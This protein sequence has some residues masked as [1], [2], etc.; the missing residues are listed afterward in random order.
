VSFN[1]FAAYYELTRSKNVLTFS[2]RALRTGKIIKIVIIFKKEHKIS[3]KMVCN[4]Y[5]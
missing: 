2:V 5:F 1:T 4:T 3:Y